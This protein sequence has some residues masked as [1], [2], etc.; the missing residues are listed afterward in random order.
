MLPSWPQLRL[1]FVA[2]VCLQTTNGST[3]LPGQYLCNMGNRLSDEKFSAFHAL[4]SRRVRALFDM[5]AQASGTGRAHH[6][7][8]YAY[9]WVMGR[10]FYR[11]H[12]ETILALRLRA[13]KSGA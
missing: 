9:Q 12:G 7:G 10:V 5:T 6:A 8:V 4:R 13:A 1:C 3:N 2:C 11:R